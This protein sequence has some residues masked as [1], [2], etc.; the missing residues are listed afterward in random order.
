VKRIHFFA[1]PSDIVPVLLR[2]G[3]NTPLK[4]VELGNL[5]TPDRATYLD[6]SDIPGPGVSTHETASCSTAYMVSLRD[7]KNHMRKFIG[8]NGEHRWTLDNGDNEETVILTMAG[9][10]GTDTLLP[11][12]MATVHQSAVAQQLMRQFLAAL[13][14]EGFY[15]IESWWLGSQAMEML[16]SCKRLTTTAVQSPPEFDLRMPQELNGES[17]Q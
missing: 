17:R 2:F 3:S 11:G 15:K 5:T 14:Q 6:A 7:A 4:F 10:W 12:L 8:R 1:T 16:K 9:L 13:N